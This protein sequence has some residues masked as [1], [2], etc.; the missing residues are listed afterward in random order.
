MQV[1]HA[2]LRRRNSERPRG[3]PP[4]SEG[5]DFTSGALLFEVR[6]L[7]CAK[8]VLWQYIGEVTIVPAEWFHCSL[9]GMV[10]L[11]SFGTTGTIFSM[12]L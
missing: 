12:S 3:S 4:A 9:P 7:C 8:L 5:L 11:K 6:L 2:F 10:Q 1:L